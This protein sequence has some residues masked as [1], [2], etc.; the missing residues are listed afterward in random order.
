MSCPIDCSIHHT[1]TPA[2]ERKSPLLEIAPNVYEQVEEYVEPTLPRLV[3]NP[4]DE[5]ADGGVAGVKNLAGAVAFIQH[6]HDIADAGIHA[7]VEGDHVVAGERAIRF[8]LLDDHH[9]LSIEV[10]MVDRRV[11]RTYD[12]AEDHE[13]M[14]WWSGGVVE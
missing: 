4:N 8:H 6:E 14:E 9:L 11:Y 3:H 12:G 7:A 13:K 10:A 2:P 1:R 5:G